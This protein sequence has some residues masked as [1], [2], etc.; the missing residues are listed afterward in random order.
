VTA[1][2]LVPLNIK[3]VVMLLNVLGERVFSVMFPHVLRMRNMNNFN[4][5]GRYKTSL[6]I[7]SLDWRDND[8]G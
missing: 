7:V 5:N 4:H 2:G 8:I 3:K 6:S 1:L